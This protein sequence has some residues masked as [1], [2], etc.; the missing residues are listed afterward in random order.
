MEIL[1]L[2]LKDYKNPTMAWITKGHV[3]KK[4]VL[5]TPKSVDM[6]VCHSEYEVVT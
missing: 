5:L 4:R 6:T 1:R 2:G 3:S